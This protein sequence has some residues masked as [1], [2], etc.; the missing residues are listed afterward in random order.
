LLDGFKFFWTQAQVLLTFIG[1]G[2]ESEIQVSMTYMLLLNLMTTLIGLPFSVYSTFVL[3]QKHGFNKQTAGFYIKDQ[4]KSLIVGQAIT[5]PLVAG[6]VAIILWGGEYFFIYLWGFTTLVMLFLM[7]VY[8]DF[9][10][11]LFD[12]YTPLPEGELRTGIETLAK[13][14][15]FPLTKLYVV[16]GTTKFFF[17]Y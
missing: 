6:I 5:L 2:I 11:P 12:K 7:T 4:I 17:K 10:A 8:P 14:I 16:E 1:L 9:I 13:S 15:H 3:E